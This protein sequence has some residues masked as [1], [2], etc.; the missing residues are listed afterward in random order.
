[1]KRTTDVNADGTSEN[2]AA[3]RKSDLYGLME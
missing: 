2:C 1:M 3:D